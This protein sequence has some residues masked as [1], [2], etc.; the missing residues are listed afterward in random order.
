M[1]LIRRPKPAAD[2]QG[3]AARSAAL[4]TLQAVFTTGRPLYDALESN[5]SKSKLAARDLAFARAIVMTALRRLGQIDEVISH[6][7]R[8]PLPARAGPA[9]M[10]LRLATAELLFL[11]VAP[12][13]AVSS[14][15]ELADHDTRARH[16]K[17]LINAVSRR[18]A[19][20]GKATLE[21]IDAERANT[22]VWAWEAWTRAFGEDA[23]RGIAKAHASEPPLDITVKSDPAAWAPKLEATI[24]PTGTL[25]R[26]PGGRIEDLP[27]YAEGAW[28]V[29]DAA[30][31]IP[32]RLLGQVKGK[33]VID[34]CAAPGGKT[35]QLANLGAKVTAVDLGFDRMKRVMANLARLNLQAEIEVADALEW[36][37][38]T[39]ADALLLD[40]PCTATGTVRRHPDVL[41]RKGVSDVLAQADLQARLLKS[42]SDMLKPGGTLVY[43]VCSLAREEGEDVIGDFL[44]I[45]SNFERVPVTPADVDG[46]AIFVTAK[47]DFRTLPSHWPER[48][49]LDGFYACRLRRTR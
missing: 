40:A 34:L 43:C 10:I 29:Q 39:L 4:A 41:W 23:A 6:F 21:T 30:A 15:V 28:W 33:T 13:A 9:E 36:R 11:E 44:A 2:T 25:R 14:A 38:K 8:E 32:V 27:G 49:G 26:L 7:L 46:E 3:L 42:A 18:I 47:G 17:G 24:L 45:H 48:G 16:F 1:G 19:A 31:S 12:H 20:E 37:P 22:P 35:A 5:L